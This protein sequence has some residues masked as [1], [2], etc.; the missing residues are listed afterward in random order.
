MAVLALLVHSRCLNMTLM[1]MAVVLPTWQVIINDRVI[2]ALHLVNS[3]TVNFDFVWDLGAHKQ[4]GI[5]PEAGSVPT[6][7][8]LV[9][10]L[11]YHPTAVDKLDGCKATC[12]VRA[13]ATDVVWGSAM[14]GE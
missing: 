14:F 11:D 1:L 4:L 8:R 9:C 13:D 10:E 7:E 5:R 12:Q 3:G 2:R 6:G